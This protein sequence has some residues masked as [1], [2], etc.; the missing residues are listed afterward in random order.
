MKRPIVAPTVALMLNPVGNLR[1]V[2]VG[3]AALAAP[4][5]ALMGVL[6]GGRH[7]ERFD[8]KQIVVSPVGD[9]VRIRE[10][11]DQDFGTF[12][13]HGYERVIPNDFGVPT[14]I[15]A[16]S[17]DAPDALSVEQLYGET[18]IRIGDADTTIS[19]QHRYVLEYTLPDAQLGGG[20]LGLDIIGASDPLEIEQFELI[21]TGF[22]FSATTCSVGGLG[23]D[24][25]CDLQADGKSYRVVISPLEA[26]RGVT[27]TGQISAL[28][29]PEPVAIPDVPTRR[30]DHRGRLALALLPLGA[31]A[32]GGSYVLA[33]RAGRNEVGGAGAADAAYGSTSVGVRFVADSELDAL[34]TTEFEPPRE[35][36]PWHGTMLLREQI[37]AQSIS[38][39]FSELIAQD[40]LSLSG[41]HPPVLSAGSKLA[42]QP[43]QTQARIAEVF[44]GG[45]ITLGAYDKALAT[46]WDAVRTEQL[47]FAKNCGWWSRFPPGTTSHFPRSLGLAV[48]VLALITAAGVFLGFLRSWPIALLIA[49]V[50]PAI[51]AFTAYRPLLPVRSAA[52]SALAIRTESFRR[53]LQASEG[54][55]VEWAWKNNL[56]REYSAWAVALGA[57]EAWGRAVASSTV[58]PAAIAQTAPL[59]MYVF[60]SQMSSSHTVPP[61]P[62]SSGGSGGG[63]SSGFS[64]GSVGGG[65]G[66][67]SSGSW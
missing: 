62:S 46:E 27:V 67:G 25:G 10:V 29:A 33:K 7:D 43:M 12:N 55:H 28:V 8:A 15:V 48:G 50:G 11:V 66:G 58:P 64:G 41:D 54:R 61:P 37:D 6:G 53:F 32:G 30:N 35:L 3:A 38:A 4:L 56:L 36:A 63:W 47:Q 1:H 17:P 18:R 60:A 65:G 42:Q 16:S 20:V 5:L 9:G 24:G 39:R 34:A 44:R 19:G 57:A 59:G 40:S 22:T 21:M 52:G 23:Q 45:P 2:A 13:R 14:D 31:F 26:N 51:A 49:V